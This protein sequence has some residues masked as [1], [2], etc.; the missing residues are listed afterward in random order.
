MQ[1]MDG[2]AHQ[3]QIKDECEKRNNGECLFLGEMIDIDQGEDE[4]D[5]DGE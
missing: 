5:E 1:C 4:E 3:C 2:T